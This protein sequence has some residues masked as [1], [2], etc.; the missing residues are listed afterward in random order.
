M[1]RIVPELVLENTE[2][3]G[4]SERSALQ[5]FDPA[6]G[7]LLWSGPVGDVELEVATA[8]A[9]WVVWASRS[10]SVRAETLRRFGNVVRS[11]HDELTTLIS[12]ETGKPQWEARNEVDAVLARIEASVSAYTERTGTRLLEGALGVRSA[13]RHKPHGIV[14]VLGPYSFPLLLPISHIAPA[15]LAGNSIVFKPSE[16]TPATGALL[17]ECL[18]TAGVP[19][20][21][22]RLLIGG[23]DIGKKLAIHP[24]VDG[25]LFTGSADVGLGLH[26]LYSEMPNK[27]LALEMGGNNPIIVWEAPDVQ[28]AAILVVQ[29]AFLS[30][31]QHCMAARRLIVQDGKEGPLL[32]QVATLIDRLIVDKADCKPAPFMG[33]MIDMDVADAMIEA[34]LDLMMKGGRPIKHM[35][36][37]MPGRPFLTAGLIDVTDVERRPDVE[38]FGPMLQVIRVPDFDAALLEANATR[39]GLSA[40]LVGG[41]PQHYD[42]FWANIRAGVVNWNRPTNNMMSSGPIGGVGLS[43]NHRPGGSYAADY[44]AYPVVS[45]EVENA[46]A[47]IGIGL[48][49]RPGLANGRSDDPFA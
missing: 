25:L 32:E 27:M 34:F 3:D 30:A 44:C 7:D 40:S 18:R 4:L 15:L 10:M 1:R 14:G 43:G 26:R 31:G 5:S 8:R 36:R 6:T 28:Q 11:R 12:C 33:P 13:L 42:R 2:L 35:A 49:D 17:V 38:Y 39:F 29:S 19:D 47:S 45:T 21:S 22:V 24:G 9:D 16:R 48:R 23:P 46:R 20:S 41:S 37:P